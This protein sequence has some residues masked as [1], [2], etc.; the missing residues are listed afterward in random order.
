[1]AERPSDNAGSA[2][3]ARVLAIQGTG[4]GTRHQRGGKTPMQDHLRLDSF[5]LS[6]SDITSVDVKMESIRLWEIVGQLLRWSSLEGCDETG[7]AAVQ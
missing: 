1:M 4:D 3:I 2:T 5:E 6:L 7:S